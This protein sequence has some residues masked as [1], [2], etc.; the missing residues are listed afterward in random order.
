[1][2]STVYSFSFMQGDIRGDMFFIKHI[3]DSF[4]VIDCN[5]ADDREG[6]IIDRIAEESKEKTI[7]RFI[8]THPDKD[9]IWGLERLVARMKMPAPLL[10]KKRGAV[11]LGVTTVTTIQ[12]M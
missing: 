7:K 9:H 5:L 3:N 2:K 6:E 4:T 1:M 11:C 12:Y 10:I 8:S